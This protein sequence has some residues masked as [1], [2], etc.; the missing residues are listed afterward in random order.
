MVFWP[1]LPPNLR[2]LTRTLVKGVYFYHF[3]GDEDGREVKW[4][5]GRLGSIQVRLGKYIRQI[6]EVL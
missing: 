2:L 3:G 4:R 5:Q 6:C 1:L